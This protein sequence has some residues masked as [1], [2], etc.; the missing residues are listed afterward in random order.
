MKE[1]MKEVS[2]D[3]FLEYWKQKIERSKTAP[4]PVL[5]ETRDLLR[6]TL[7]IVRHVIDNKGTSDMSRCIVESVKEV[8]PIIP[9]R[10]RRKL[11]VDLAVKALRNQYGV[12]DARK[13]LQAE[14]CL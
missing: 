3:E 13:Q 8:L 1:I 7:A 9:T 4:L 12:R 10:K 11:I 14:G 5:R 6:F 2:P